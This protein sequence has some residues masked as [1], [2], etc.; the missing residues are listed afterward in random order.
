MKF[1]LLQRWKLRGGAMEDQNLSF[2]QLRGK[3]YSDRH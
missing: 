3:Y 2:T 1:Y